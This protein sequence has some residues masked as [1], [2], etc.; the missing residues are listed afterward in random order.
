MGST[1][2]VSLLHSLDIPCTPFYSAKRLALTV[3]HCG[4]TRA[5]LCSTN[6]GQ[7]QS[8]TEKHHADARGEAARLRRLGTGLITDSYGEARWMGAV[9]NTR[10][11]G[12][13]VFK[14]FGVTPEP[15]MTSRILY[16][17]EWAYLIMVSDGVSSILSDQEVVDVARHAK[18]P[19][20]A[21]DNIVA[22]AE[23]LGTEDNASAMVIP[24]AGWG[25]ID[26][27]DK[28]KDLR[29]YRQNQAVG[30]ERQRRM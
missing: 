12:D 17:P 15:Q 2:T 29:V 4:D 1:A 30:S 18:T 6:G 13:G 5:L 24:L 28:T 8:L 21:A 20:A 11:L 10:G 14:R 7:V 23:E 27:P 25:K 26:G 22:F 19:K 3:A 9:E 16:S